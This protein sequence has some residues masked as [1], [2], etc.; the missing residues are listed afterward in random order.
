MK[1]ERKRNKEKSDL[2]NTKSHLK[3][4]EIDPSFKKFL[5]TIIR[6]KLVK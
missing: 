2:D 1:G 6:V 5:S 4:K 3:I